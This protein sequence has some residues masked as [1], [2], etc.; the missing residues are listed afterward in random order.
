MEK[1]SDTPGRYARILLD[2]WFKRSFGSERWKRLLILFL[3]EI[4]PERTIEELTFVS[5]EHLNPSPEKK[6]IRIDVE[7][8]DKDGTRFVVEMQLTPQYDFYQ[9]AVFNSTFAIQQQME[10][11]SSG[12]DFP[13]VYFVGLL[14]FSLHKN[15]DRVLFRYDLRERENRELMTDRIQYVFLELPNCRRALTPEASILDNFC[16]AL[17]N[18]EKLPEKPLGFDSELLQLLFDSAEIA[19]FTPQERTKYDLDMR[20][21]RDFKN[22]LFYAREEG[23]KEGRKEGREEGR[24][25][26]LKEIT[27]HL[28][29]KGMSQEEV[30]AILSDVLHESK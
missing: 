20:T 21:E 3:Q 2:Y 12:Y 8:V 17:H 14:D 1:N 27:E 15:S 7:C 11:G 26:A 29:A 6:G 30:D 9:R 4:I 24:E 19:N 16:Y 28:L 23:K 22:Q 5:Q 18:M 25:S 10:K 13:P